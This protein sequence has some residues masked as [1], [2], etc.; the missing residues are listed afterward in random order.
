MDIYDA[1]YQEI[2][3]AP[4]YPDVAEKAKRK[5]FRLATAGEVRA[6]ANCEWHA[7][8]LYSAYGVNWVKDDRH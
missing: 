3:A 2:I 4:L 6:S 5:G 8:D 1:N 7:P